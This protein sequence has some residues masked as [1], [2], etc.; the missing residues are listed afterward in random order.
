MEKFLVSCQ[1]GK[2]TIHQGILHQNE[3]SQD[4]QT[5]TTGPTSQHTRT[6]MPTHQDHDANTQ[7]PAKI[8]RKE[9]QIIR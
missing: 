3:Q 4:H 9:D 7:P 6:N 1:A 8:D 5:N 2:E